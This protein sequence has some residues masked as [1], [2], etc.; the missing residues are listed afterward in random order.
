MNHKTKKFLRLTY[1]IYFKTCYGIY[2]RLPAPVKRAHKT[3]IECATELLLFA[4]LP[5]KEAKEISAGVQAIVTEA[6]KAYPTLAERPVADVADAVMAY[7]QQMN[8]SMRRAEVDS[9]K[10]S[11]GTVN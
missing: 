9:K 7:M 11:N 2:K 8:F 4:F 1:G 5:E 3:S 10:E 6:Y